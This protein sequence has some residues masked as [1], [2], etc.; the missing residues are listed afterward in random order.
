MANESVSTYKVGP[1][2]QITATVFTLLMVVGGAYHL[3]GK[4][5]KVESRLEAVETH[6]ETLPDLRKELVEIRIRMAAEHSGG[7]NTNTT[8][9]IPTGLA[10]QLVE[11]VRG[12]TAT[13]LAARCDVSRDTVY[14][15]L[16]DPAKF[17]G[18]ALMTPDK[19]RIPAK[20]DGGA[21]WFEN[22]EYKAA[23]DGKSGL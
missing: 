2:I 16:K 4:V 7:D 20:K 22:P 10:D 1:N 12:W 14:A 21:W 18:T 9:I 3:G 8:T 15:W 23:T 11:N 13:Q 19:L 6:V 17:D 5:T